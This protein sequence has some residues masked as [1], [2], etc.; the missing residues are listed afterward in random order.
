MPELP[1]YQKLLV[2]LGPA[3]IG[4]TIQRLT[5]PPTVK[6]PRKY[7]Q[8][9]WQ[10]FLL[11]VTSKKITKI[12]RLGK[13]LMVFFEDSDLFWHIHLNSTGWFMP[14][15][16]AAAE[17]TKTDKIARNFIHKIIAANVRIRF[18]F[19]DGQEWNYHDARTWGKWY[20]RKGETARDDQYLA[21]LG[22][23]WGFEAERAV[24]ALRVH[25]TKRTLK[26][27]LCDQHVTQGLG[28]YLAC[29]IANRAGIHP[30]E[31]YDHLTDFDRVKLCTKVL[32]TLT[33][34][35]QAEDHEHWRVF[36]RLGEDCLTHIGE[37]IKYA[38]DG[39][40]TGCRG[41][42]YCPVC[43][44]GPFYRDDE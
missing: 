36:K 39:E 1:E 10:S 16:Q 14:N 41:S 7:Y 31:P 29:E 23:D 3:W 4:N 43:Q 21:S 24:E 28:N 42:Y 6:N 5:A 20:L 33:E 17:A 8:G 40:A 2:Q 25:R 27:V 22:P 9:E 37:K 38:K 34:C 30:H 18:H 13:G 11:G 44:P 35:M 32:E 15:N 26:D 12:E 19:A